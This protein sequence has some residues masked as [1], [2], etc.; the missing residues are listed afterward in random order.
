MGVTP[1]GGEPPRSGHVG[2]SRNSL[3]SV[4][5]GS[6]GCPLGSV[7]PGPLF[8][9]YG[10]EL[11]EVIEAVC[12]AGESTK[13]PEI[14][15]VVDPSS[16]CLTA[17]RLI[18]GGGRAL[19]AVGASRIT[20]NGT[21]YPGP[22]PAAILPEVVQQEIRAVGLDPRRVAA[23]SSKQPKVA[24]SIESGTRSPSSAWQVEG[25]GHVLGAIDTRHV[26]AAGMER[27]CFRCNVEIPQIIQ[28]GQG[29]ILAAE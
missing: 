3:G 20:R 12:A 7:H 6:A 16:G 29:T 17:R 22:L 8:S 18:G 5:S 28:E 2:S 24:G 23:K 25:R 15:S 21:T 10:I 19:G 27:P 14:P 26:L 4:V 11:P 9:S 1:S 13:H